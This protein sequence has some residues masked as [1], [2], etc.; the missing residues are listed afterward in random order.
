MFN[1]PN[2]DVEAE[3]KDQVKKAKFLSR[4]S[5]FENL[6]TKQEEERKVSKAEVL[7]KAKFFET[8]AEEDTAQREKEEKE[9]EQRK[10]SFDLIKQQFES[11]E[12]LQQSD[13]SGFGSIED[14]GST[15]S[16]DTTTSTQPLDNLEEATEEV[17]N[18]EAS[19]VFS[20]EETISERARNIS[21]SEN[22]ESSQ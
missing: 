12:T 20:E 5:K 16:T 7:K 14:I 8:G 6:N 22:S 10:M 18:N 3:R 21:I 1:K 4:L 15:I 13:S 11:E 17:S 19:D 9:K 2:V